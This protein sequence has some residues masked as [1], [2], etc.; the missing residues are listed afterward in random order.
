LAIKWK[1]AAG[2]SASQNFRRCLSGHDQ[3]LLSFSLGHPLAINA[4]HSRY[5]S[6]FFLFRCP[7][8]IYCHL[9][10]PFRAIKRFA[11]M[12]MGSE[13]LMW[14]THAVKSKRSHS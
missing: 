11:M 14:L 12:T 9:R 8:N 13:M 5:F 1:P 6:C 3:H 4:R 10:F 7:R 2:H